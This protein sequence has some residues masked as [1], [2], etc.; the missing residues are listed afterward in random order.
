MCTT[1]F[2]YAFHTKLRNTERFYDEEVGIL[3]NE[4]IMAYRKHY[5][6]I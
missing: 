1:L 4:V 5:Y 6:T 2:G 3:W